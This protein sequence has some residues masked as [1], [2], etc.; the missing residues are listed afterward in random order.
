[1]NCPSC[2]LQSLEGQKFCRS[3]GTAL[4]L[5]TRPLVTPT[6]G[7]EV[8]TVKDLPAGGQQG[9]AWTLWAF[10]LMFL[11]VAIGVIGKMALH[12]EVVTVVGV[13]LS[14]AGM[15]LTALPNERRSC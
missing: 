13:L 12:N 5:T 6:T 10:A 4:Q 14:V 15:F 3:C 8:I 2:G 1:M 11:G 9:S 7:P